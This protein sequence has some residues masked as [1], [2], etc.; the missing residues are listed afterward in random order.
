LKKK[1]IHPF[2]IKT[3]QSSRSRLR[4]WNTRHFWSWVPTDSNSDW[5]PDFHCSDPRSLCSDHCPQHLRS[6]NRCL[7]FQRFPSA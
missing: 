7:S 3:G 4:C 2:Q 1:R 5:K 6:S